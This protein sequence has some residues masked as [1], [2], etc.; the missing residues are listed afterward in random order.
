MLSNFATDSFDEPCDTHTHTRANDSV[1]GSHRAKTQYNLCVSMVKVT[2]VQNACR[3]IESIH[4]HAA[5]SKDVF[6]CKAMQR[7][8]C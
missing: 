1:G 4:F 6:F 7:A 3:A 8:Q 2:M 5:S